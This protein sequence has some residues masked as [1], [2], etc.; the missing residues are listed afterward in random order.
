MNLFQ[1]HNAVQVLMSYESTS[2]RHRVLLCRRKIDSRATLLLASLVP[3]TT[4]LHLPQHPV[5]VAFPCRYTAPSKNAGDND[6]SQPLASVDFD[7]N[8]TLQ[9]S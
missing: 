1:S 6:L 4:H 3:W 5:V 7:F 9:G 8:L 2:I